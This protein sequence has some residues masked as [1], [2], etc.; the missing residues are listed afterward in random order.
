MQHL[1]PLS[2]QD[3]YESMLKELSPAQLRQ[4]GKTHLTDYTPAFHAMLTELLNKSNQ[5]VVLDD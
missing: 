3:T 2:D 5:E 1:L 4:F